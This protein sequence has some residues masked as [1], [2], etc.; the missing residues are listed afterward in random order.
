MDDEIALAYEAMN[1]VEL[2]HRRVSKVALAYRPANEVALSHRAAT[3]IAGAQEDVNLTLL[4]HIHYSKAIQ[5]RHI[6]R[7]KKVSANIC[8]I[9]KRFF[10]KFHW[11][12]SKMN[13]LRVRIPSRF[14]EYHAHFFHFVP[15]MCLIVCWF[16]KA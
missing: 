5:V 11:N 1:K 6:H 3:K 10:F 12:D 7:I 8:V 9:F 2:A 13:I 14:H 16:T 4:G 15:F